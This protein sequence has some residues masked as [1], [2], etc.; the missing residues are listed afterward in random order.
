MYGI[1]FGA[2]KLG[3]SWATLTWKLCLSFV[4][5]CFYNCTVQ[6]PLF[7]LPGFAISYLA[8]TDW[9]FEIFKHSLEICTGDFNYQ[10]GCT[11][12]V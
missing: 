8:I 10:P 1:E 2:S 12:S 4:R 5:I 3:F 6:D 11:I 7:D 9:E